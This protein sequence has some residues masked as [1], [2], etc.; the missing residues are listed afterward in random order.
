MPCPAVRTET[1]WIALQKDGTILF[2]RGPDDGLYRV[3]AKANS[4]PTQVLKVNPDKS[5]TGYL[6]PQFLPLQV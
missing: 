1:A 3:T 4:T 5:E 6:W 2:A